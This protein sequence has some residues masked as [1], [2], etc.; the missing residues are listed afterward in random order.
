MLK[1]SLVIGPADNPYMHRWHLIR[2]RGLQL[3]LHHIMR[4]DDDRALHDHSGDNWSLIL[5]GTPYSEVVREYLGTSPDIIYRVDAWQRDGEGRLYRD[6][7]VQR[8]AWHIY[9]RKAEIPHR[10]I[11]DKGQS[12]WTLW[13]RLPPRRDWG[14]HC[15]KGWM[16]W[17]RY[18]GEDYNKTGKSPI[19]RGC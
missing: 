15:P 5:F 18:I 16:H 9:F 14:F 8:K 1:P 7:I 11:L 17:K 4:S 6:R 2:A 3:A 19:G 12:V 13:L 10:L